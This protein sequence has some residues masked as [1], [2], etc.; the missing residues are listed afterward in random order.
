MEMDGSVGFHVSPKQF[1]IF[2]TLGT[3][4]M[5]I[6]TIRNLFVSLAKSSAYHMLCS[7]FLSTG[8]FDT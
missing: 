4:V 6:V 1:L 3:A 8:G 7:W 2:G 5:K